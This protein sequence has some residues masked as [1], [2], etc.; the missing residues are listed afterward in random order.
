M[1]RKDVEL[2]S[3]IGK[4]GSATSRDG[5]KLHWTV[6]DEIHYEQ[7]SSKILCLEKIKFEWGEVEVRVGYYMLMRDNKTWIWARFSPI[8]PLEA[9]KELVEIAQAKGWF[10][11]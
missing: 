9:F 2:P 10:A 7:S 3:R 5:A 6:L 1:R 8:M 11:E 4:Q